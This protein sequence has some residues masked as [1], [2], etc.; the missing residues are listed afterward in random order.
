VP[1]TIWGAVPPIACSRHITNAWQPCAGLAGPVRK[2]R[3]TITIIDASGLAHQ[4]RQLGEI[5]RNPP[6]LTLI[7][8]DLKNTS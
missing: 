4:L 3:R 7:K 1:I 6:R 8:P 2:V 5:H